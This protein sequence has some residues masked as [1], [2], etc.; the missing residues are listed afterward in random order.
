MK[1]E[2][3]ERQLRQL[4]PRQAPP[5]LRQRVLAQQPTVSRTW[6][7]NRPILAG[8]AAAWLL[9]LF[10]HLDTP[11][12]RDLA[13]SHSPA[14]TPHWLTHLALVQTWL[15]SPSEEIFP[16]PFPTPKL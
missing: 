10:F 4:P 15:A 12:T 5:A 2:D 6:W 16:A 8:I 13:S 7:W 1:T 11:P 3:L 14:L 9:I